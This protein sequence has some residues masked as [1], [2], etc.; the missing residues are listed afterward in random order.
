VR[1]GAP[2]LER[3]LRTQRV[4]KSGVG[5]GDIL[6]ETSGMGRARMECTGQG[7]SREGNEDWTVKK[8]LKS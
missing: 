5:G 2:T 7:A 1:E 6:L 4:R 8:E 3:D